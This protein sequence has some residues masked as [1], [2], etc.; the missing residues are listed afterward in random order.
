MVVLI[1]VLSG[2]FFIIPFDVCLVREK[3][4]YTVAATNPSGTFM[5]LVISYPH[6]VNDAML[7]KPHVG[8]P[9]NPSALALDYFEAID[10]RPVLQDGSCAQQ[11]PN[12]IHAAGE[13]D[14]QG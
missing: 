14:N 7:I 6:P 4:K 2:V 9:E 1:G 12:E 11:I 8:S 5:S 13:Q 3:T 10:A